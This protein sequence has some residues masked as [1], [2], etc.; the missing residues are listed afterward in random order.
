MDCRKQAGCSERGGSETPAGTSQEIYAPSTKSHG[1]QALTPHFNSSHHLR[2]TSLTQTPNGSFWAQDNLIT[3]IPRLPAAPAA[4]ARGG[5]GAGTRRCHHCGLPAA[6]QGPGAA[7][8]LALAPSPGA[9]FARLFNL[10]LYLSNFLTLQTR[11]TD[12]MKKNKPKVYQN[13]HSGTAR[14]TLTISSFL[15]KLLNERL[16]L[17]DSG[18]GFRRALALHQVSTVVNC[19]TRVTQR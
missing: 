16:S 15:S 7:L 17:G 13:S 11:L 1:P 9:L 19:D 6:R 14:L 8:V 2:K 18:S 5:Q 3:L 4:G 12:T 10:N